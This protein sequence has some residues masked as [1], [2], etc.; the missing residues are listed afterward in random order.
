MHRSTNTGRM[1]QARGDNVCEAQL[2][3]FWLPLTSTSSGKPALPAIFPEYK[4]QT[5]QLVNW[6]PANLKTVTGRNSTAIDIEIPQTKLLDAM[7]WMN[8]HLYIH[9]AGR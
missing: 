1:P 3:E 9:I 2:Q 7:H 6:V 8:L 5:K 4:L